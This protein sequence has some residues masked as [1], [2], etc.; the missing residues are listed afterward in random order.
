[1]RILSDSEADS[2]N[3]PDR[4][5]RMIRPHPKDGN[6]K[7]A[8]TI[9][10][11]RPTV[12]ASQPE[13][14]T[15]S[16]VRAHCD[17][18]TIEHFHIPAWL[19]SFFSGFINLATAILEHARDSA[20]EIRGF[21][22]LILFYRGRFLALELKTEVGSM[23]HAQKTWQRRLGTIQCRTTAEACKMIEDWKAICDT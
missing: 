23:T 14:L 9:G 3:L 8:R 11:D 6:L 1:M 20:E 17:T 13:S 5:S 10:K 18:L 4:L 7:F 19:L 21:P 12:R 2:A 22:D 15:L 16:E